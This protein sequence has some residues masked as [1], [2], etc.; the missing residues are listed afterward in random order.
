MKHKNFVSITENPPPKYVEI[1]LVLE[2]GS[3]AIGFANSVGEIL[4]ANTR[5]YNMKTSFPEFPFRPIKW[6]QM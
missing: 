2:D 6:R 5:D 4:P 1:R 3:Y